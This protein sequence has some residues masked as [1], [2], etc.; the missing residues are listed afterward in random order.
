MKRTMHMYK[1]VGAPNSAIAMV[2]GQSGFMC[3]RGSGFE[4]LKRDCRTADL[5]YGIEQLQFRTSNLAIS[6]K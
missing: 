4:Q 3:G 5:N 1:A 6:Y 2:N